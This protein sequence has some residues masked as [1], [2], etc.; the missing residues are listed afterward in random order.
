MLHDP[1][2]IVPEMAPPG[3][4]AKSRPLVVAP[5]VTDTAVPVAT[6]VLGLHDA[7]HLTLVEDLKEMGRGMAG[8]R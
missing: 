2:V 3:L 4:S 1:L 7:R 8:Q 6:A 5:A